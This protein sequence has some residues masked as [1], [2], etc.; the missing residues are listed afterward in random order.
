MRYNSTRRE[1]LRQFG[2][3]AAA[4]PF[5]CNLPSLGFENAA[6]RKKRLVI[7]FSPNGVVRK[8]F[9]PDEAGELTAF[10]EILA[11]LDPYKD[12]TLVLNGVSDQI[13]G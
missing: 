11:P 7:M 4:F 5:I 1:F 6:G 3:S 2:L 9:W 8:N 13:R 12:R 10:K